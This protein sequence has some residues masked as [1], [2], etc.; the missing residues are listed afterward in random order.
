MET[1]NELKIQ[2]VKL[3]NE[4]LKLEI[5][6]LTLVLDQNDIIEKH[7]KVVMG[8][9][10]TL[11]VGI[12]GQ[13]KLCELENLGL[14]IFPSGLVKY[15]Q[16]LLVQRRKE[17]KSLTEELSILRDQLGHQYQAV[18]PIHYD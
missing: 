15:R 7:D 12:I 6:K 5:E 13:D 16:H 2:Q 11:A 3:E 18:R 4:K 17:I 9:T 1:L 10:R 8:D 14:K